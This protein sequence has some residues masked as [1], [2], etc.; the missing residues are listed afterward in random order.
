MNITK[1][2]TVILRN[3]RAMKV[4][5]VQVLE[6]GVPGEEV[7]ARCS[8]LPGALGPDQDFVVYPRDIIGVVEFTQ[9]SDPMI[10]SILDS[11]PR[12]D[13]YFAVV[14]P[15][16]NVAALVSFKS[17]AVMTSAQA[18]VA[19]RESVTRWTV[20]TY[21]GTK[22][23]DNSVGEFSLGDL[24]SHLE[25]PRLRVFL[26]AF[27]IYD[28]RIDSLDLSSHQADWNYDTLLVTDSDELKKRLQPSEERIPPTQLT[29]PEA[30]TEEDIGNLSWDS[31][32]KEDDATK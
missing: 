1:D 25:D 20:Q 7:M 15:E 26:K 29:D 12:V 30:E 14:R 13:N 17:P 18:L 5:E 19:I 6:G 11:M 22:A 16:S 32:R 31:G 9:H 28:M 3:G 23:W 8:S 10:Q 4:D 27:G 2:D 24:I 21:E